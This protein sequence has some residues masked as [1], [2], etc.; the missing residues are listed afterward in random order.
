MQPLPFIRITF[1]AWL[2]APNAPD[3]SL[4]EV[5]VREVRV[6]IATSRCSLTTV[7]L[8]RANGSSLVAAK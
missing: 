8:C 4:K 3:I 6:I 5:K 7:A 2:S 1:L